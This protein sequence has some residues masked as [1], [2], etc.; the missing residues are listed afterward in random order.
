MPTTLRSPSPA[1]QEAFQDLAR[2]YRASGVDR[3]AEALDDYGAF[4]LRISAQSRQETCGKGYVAQDHYW[5]VDDEGRALGSCR[6]RHRL[7]PHL[8]IEGGHVGYDIR[9]GHRGR[10]HATRL[11]ALTLDV[12]RRR[13]VRR[14]LITCDHD[15]RASARVIEKNG[16]VEWSTSI[17]PRSGKVVRRF[18]IDLE[19]RP[20]GDDTGES[21]P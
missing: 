11:L 9:P 5:L 3:Y 7:A 6:V 4:L 1:L 14:A 19:P 8:E 10:G 2:E 13:G 15:N 18:W 17:S 12:L 20:G 21:P 16:G